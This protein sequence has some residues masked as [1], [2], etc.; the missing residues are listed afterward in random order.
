[1]N[2]KEAVKLA[3]METNLKNIEKK[4]DEHLLDQKSDFEK[5]F[6]KI[7]QFIESAESRY[8]LKT[9]LNEIKKKIT[10]SSISSTVWVRNVIQ[11]TI[12]IMML[13]VTIY[14]AIKGGNI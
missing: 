6:N 3:V 12:A 2:Q 7:D 1:M 9:E 13:I 11:W 8:A 5:V 14:V 10:S 4:L